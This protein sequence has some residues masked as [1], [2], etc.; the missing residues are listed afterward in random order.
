[1]R[2]A[3]AGRLL[4]PFL[5][6][7][8]LLPLLGAF[9]GTAAAATLTNGDFETGDLTGWTTFVTPNGTIG[10]TNGSSGPAGV[11]LFDTTGSGA[12]YAAHFSV[13]EIAGEVGNGPSEGGG[14]YQNVT[15]AAG[16]YVLSADI[17]TDGGFN[18]DCGLYELI[19][20]GHLVA[21]HD[22]GECLAAGPYRST[23]DATVPLSDGSH[24]IRILI[25]RNYAPD[26]T[27][28]QYVDNVSLVPLD[29]TPPVISVPGSVTANATSSNGAVVTY[30]VTATDPDDAV[31]SL[32]CVPASGSV[33]PIGTTTVNCTAA[34]THGNTSSASF[35]V[36]V[37][38]ASEQISDLSSAVAGVGPGTS[39]GH[40]VTR[41]QAALD[42]NDVGGACSILGAFINEV[43]AQLGQSIPPD[44]ASALITEATGIRALLGC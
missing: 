26:F 28:T 33:F 25:T 38:D 19:V 36:H 1:M 32:V 12:S 30:L 16:T 23:L 14:I 13:G 39:L 7:M 10:S 41:A 18:A 22:F 4:R 44:T 42:R 37:L 29:S 2:K 17:A 15:V 9:P 8:V 11:A 34:D 21:S 27:M 40:K 5:L 31:A 43:Q 35:T 20:D 3:S 6:V 24:E